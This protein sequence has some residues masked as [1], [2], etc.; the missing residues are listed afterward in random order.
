[1]QTQ[2][3]LK[4]CPATELPLD[5]TAQHRATVIHNYF[6]FHLSTIWNCF[7]E[8]GRGRDL[9][10]DHIQHSLWKQ[11][12]ALQAECRGFGRLCEILASW[13][14]HLHEHCSHISFAVRT[15][16]SWTKWL[17]AL[18]YRK[19]SRGMY[20]EEWHGNVF[21]HS[22]GSIRIHPTVEL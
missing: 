11:W 5:G 22:K 9:Q 14:Q 16:S 17:S 1:M 19:C 6:I 10:G 20:P 2:A 21:V 4:M 8:P 18:C 15:A 3:A 7:T 12:E 13:N